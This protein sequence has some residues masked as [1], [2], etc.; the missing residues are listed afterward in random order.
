[1]EKTD[2]YDR[3]FSEVL[4]FENKGED[5]VFQSDPTGPEMFVFVKFKGGRQGKTQSDS[6]I[7]ADVF[8][9]H[10]EITKKEYDN[11]K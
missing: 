5:A 10:F 7:F 4:Y 1:M 3:M 11:F 2:F 9:P 8:G 6:K